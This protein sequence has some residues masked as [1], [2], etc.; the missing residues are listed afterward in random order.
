MKTRIGVYGARSKTIPNDYTPVFNHYQQASINPVD[1]GV[2]PFSIDL[3]DS[4][5]GSKDDHA[6][7]N[8]SP[9][10]KRLDLVYDV[11]ANQIRTDDGRGIGRPGK[12]ITVK[13]NP[14]KH[15]ASVTFILR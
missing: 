5:F 15:Q 14:G 6:D 10:K 13:G 11:Q 3:Y 2:Y 9:N 7:I 1:G 8:P 12:A 4:D